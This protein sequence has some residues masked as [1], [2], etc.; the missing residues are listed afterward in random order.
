MFFTISPQLIALY[1]RWEAQPSGGSRPLRES[2]S[3]QEALGTAPGVTHGAGAVRG[4][5]KQRT[6]PQPGVGAHSCSRWP[7]AEAADHCTVCHHGRAN[8]V[9]SAGASPPEIRSEVASDRSSVLEQCF[10]SQE[11]PDPFS[12]PS[13]TLMPSASFLFSEIGFRTPRCPAYKLKLFCAGDL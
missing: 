6:Q 1:S 13:Q 10:L 4:L 3:T 7:E 8:P 12:P 11:G 5:E 9:T 2:P